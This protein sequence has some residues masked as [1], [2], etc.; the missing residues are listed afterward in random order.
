MLPRQETALLQVASRLSR[1]WQ[2]RKDYEVSRTAEDGPQP[3][4]SRMTPI[5]ACYFAAWLVEVVPASFFLN[6]GL[7]SRL[8]RSRKGTPLS[9]HSGRGLPSR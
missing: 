3:V 9:I 4:L 8:P 5:R 7:T 6:I 1:V 2:E